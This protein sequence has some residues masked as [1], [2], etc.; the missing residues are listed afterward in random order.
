MCRTSSPKPPDF[1]KIMFRTR[2]KAWAERTVLERRRYE[3]R[4]VMRQEEKWTEL[5]DDINAVQEELAIRKARVAKEASQVKALDVSS[6]SWSSTTLQLFSVLLKSGTYTEPYVMRQRELLT[7]APKP[8]GVAMLRELGNQELREAQPKP[9]PAWLSKVTS[10]R[11]SFRSIAL[12]IKVGGADQVVKFLYAKQ[13]MPEVMVGVRLIPRTYADQPFADVATYIWEE[14]AMRAW[15]FVFDVDGA[16]SF[17]SSDFVE[18]SEAEISV[19]DGFQWWRDGIAVADHGPIPL[20]TFLGFARWT[21]IG[22]AA[23]RRVVAAVRGPMPFSMTCRGWSVTVSSRSWSAR[24]ARALSIGMWTTLRMRA[25]SLATMMMLS[26]ITA[27]RYVF[28]KLSS[29]LRMPRAMTT[30]K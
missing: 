27:P 24:R 1:H 13:A 22:R 6:A 4:A 26:R 18:V 10:R 7:I 28:C 17:N 20:T 9:K 29:R 23:A 12:I 21:G 16:T 8:P 14:A 15:R 11:F 30:S 25:T 5:R 19:I 2:S 3:R